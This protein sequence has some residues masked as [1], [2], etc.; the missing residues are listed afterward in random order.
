MIDLVKALAVH[1]R[2]I[3]KLVDVTDKQ[4]EVIS[5][6]VEKGKYSTQLDIV[7]ALI[8][9]NTDSR[10]SD[11]EGDNLAERLEHMEEYIDKL[12][13]RVKELEANSHNKHNCSCGVCKQGGISH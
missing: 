3:K 2:A 8:N 9:S 1:E 4:H 10:L 12:T 13:K 7:Q 11:L 5:D 6:L